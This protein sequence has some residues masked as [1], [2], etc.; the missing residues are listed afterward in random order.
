MLRLRAYKDDLAIA[1][2]ATEN[3]NH[4][5]E[6]DLNNGLTQ[7]HTIFTFH[8][9]A[10]PFVQI[11]SPGHKAAH[12]KYLFVVQPFQPH[13]QRS[14]RPRCPCK[15]S[16][17]VN[18]DESIHEREWTTGPQTGRREQFWMIRPVPS[19]IDLST[20]PPR[21]LHT[22]TGAKCYLAN[23]G[24]QWLEDI[25]A[26]AYRHHVLSPMG[27]KRQK[28]NPPNTPQQDSPVPLEP[29]QYD[30]P[31]IPGPSKA[32]EP[33]EDPLTHEPEPEVAPTKSME[34]PFGKSN[35]TF[36][37]LLNFSSPLLWPSPACPATPASVII[38]N[39]T[40]VRYPPP[41][42]P[43]PEIPLISPKNPTTSSPWRQAPLNPMMRLS[44][45]LQNCDQTP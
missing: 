25:K 33:H 30:E 5:P 17:V 38:I 31:P 41:S 2:W 44:R 11:L 15:D 22:L 45:N 27:L 40:P 24:W 35:F 42:T 16:F 29:S 39:N 10:Q 26:W 19:S 21:P 12:K 23:E 8:T 34:E 32:S 43:T 13:G 14:S 36:F 20:P 28:Q 4:D 9:A 1:Q 18:D 3:F 7:A 37:T 6:A